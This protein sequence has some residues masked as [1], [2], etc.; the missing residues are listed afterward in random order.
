MTDAQINS[1]TVTAFTG[2]EPFWFRCGPSVER[3]GGQKSSRPKVQKLCSIDNHSQMNLI[4]SNRVF[5]GETNH[6]WGADP[7]GCQPKNSMA[8]MESQCLR[9]FYEGTF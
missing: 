7:I 9:R 4:F 3:S 1:E 5:Y 2:P 8:S 6:S